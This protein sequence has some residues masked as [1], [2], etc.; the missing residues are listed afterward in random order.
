MRRSDM[1][2]EILYAPAMRSGVPFFSCDPYISEPHE[3]RPEISRGYAAI[4]WNRGV[5]IYLHGWSHCLAA[6]EQ[7]RATP[8]VHRAQSA[9]DVVDAA[10]EEEAVHDED[11]AAALR[12]EV[13]RRVA[14]ESRAELREARAPRHRGMIRE[15]SP[16]EAA[17]RRCMQKERMA[18]VQ[19]SCTAASALTLEP[20]ASSLCVPPPART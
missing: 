1:P 20:H 13:A 19:N 7:V 2:V 14:P 16:Q 17:G 10:G 8:R 18:Q 12:R 11:A 5:R 4:S 6:T 3:W 9:G 15:T